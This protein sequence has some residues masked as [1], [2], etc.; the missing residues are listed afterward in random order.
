MF[1]LIGSVLQLGADVTKVALAP[2]EIVVDLADAVVKPVAQVAEEVV[3]EIKS[4][5]D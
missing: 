1:G 3:Q 5:K 2:V 4:L